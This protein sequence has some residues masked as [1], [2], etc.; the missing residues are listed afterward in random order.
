MRLLVHDHA[1][2]LG[3]C[4][5]GTEEACWWR[6]P[7]PPDRRPRVGQVCEVAAIS[8]HFNGRTQLR[9]LAMRPAQTDQLAAFV[10]SARR[11]LGELI[12]ELDGRI[13]ALDGEMGTLTRAVLT[14]EVAERFRTWPAAHSRHGAVRHGLLDHSL[15]VATLAERLADA[16]APLLQ[17][18]AHLVTAGCLLHDV[19]KVYTL[20]R[21]RARPFRMA[22]RSPTT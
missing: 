15:R 11:P 3:I 9:I 1:V 8:D 10:A 7:Y 13:G 21:F 18:D 17:Y 22:R 20:P 4:H 5:A 6:Y 16:Y 2:P 14:D 19:G 12:A